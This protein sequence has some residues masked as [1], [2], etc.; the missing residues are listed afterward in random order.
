MR[1]PPYVMKISGQ[2]KHPFPFCEDLLMTA[3]HLKKENHRPQ[4][5]EVVNMESF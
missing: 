2:T 3:S 5:Y 1:I 4:K